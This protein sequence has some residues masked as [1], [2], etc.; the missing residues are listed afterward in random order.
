MCLFF[1]CIHFTIWFFV[2]R[3]LRHLQNDSWYSKQGDNVKLSL[4][5]RELTMSTPLTY[6]K[7]QILKYM[8]VT[9]NIQLLMHFVCIVITDIRRTGCSPYIYINTY[10]SKYA[11]HVISIIPNTSFLCDTFK[12]KGNLNKKF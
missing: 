7:I 1:I 3:N 4:Q 8:H 6:R 5:E 2:C 10:G 9:I 12:K 11:K